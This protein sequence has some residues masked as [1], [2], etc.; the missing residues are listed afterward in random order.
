MRACLIAILLALMTNVGFA[1]EAF[2]TQMVGKN[3]GIGAASAH[4]D[5]GAS[6]PLRIA[7]PITLDGAK[8]LATAT[9]GPMNTSYLSQAGANNLASIS[10]TGG[11]NLSVTMQTGTGNQ[12]VV[13]QRR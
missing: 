3:L 6:L 5:A 7:S 4:Y 11:Y 9:S 12:A 10:Q 8:S 13:V 1:S 2:V